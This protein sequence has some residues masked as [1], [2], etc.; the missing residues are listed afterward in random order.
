MRV[1]AP[2][3]ERARALHQAPDIKLFGSKKSKVI[4]LFSAYCIVKHTAGVDSDILS[5][6][7]VSV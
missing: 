2:V 6:C 1:R 3:R 5:E 7:E 4:Y